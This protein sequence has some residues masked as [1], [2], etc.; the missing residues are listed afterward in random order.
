MKLEWVNE[1]M[2][3]LISKNQN[4]VAISLKWEV[5]PQL[6]T[7]VLAAHVYPLFPLLTVL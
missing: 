5:G 6:L 4:T 1:G 7:V 2:S 3:E